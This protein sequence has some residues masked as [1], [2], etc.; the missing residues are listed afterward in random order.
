[1]RFSC[2]VLAHL[3]LCG[4][5]EELPLTDKAGSS[6]AYLEGQVSA[7]LAAAKPEVQPELTILL[8]ANLNDQVSPPNPK[9]P[10]PN[11][12]SKQVQ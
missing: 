6:L 11:I 5:L 3:L 10:L 4:W 1:M 9:V 12:M 7:R 2:S 8:R